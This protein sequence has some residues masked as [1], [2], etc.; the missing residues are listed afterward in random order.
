MTKIPSADVIRKVQTLYKENQDAARLFDG[1]AGRSRDASVTTIDNVARTLGMYR[2]DAIALAKAIAE[3]GCAEYSVGRR[4][5]KT[6]LIWSYSCIS[7]GQAAAGEATTLEDI[8]D[9][10]PEDESME[11]ETSVHRD[12][13][14]HKFLSIAEAKSG[15]ALTFGVLETQIDIVIRA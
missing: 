13:A 1:L 2:G 6:R 4:G 8:T 15:L 14:P 9:P 5:S 12:S 7:V 3:T 11:R 10:E